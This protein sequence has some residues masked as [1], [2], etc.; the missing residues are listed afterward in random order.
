MKND[1]IDRLEIQKTR[2]KNY[3]IEIETPKNKDIISS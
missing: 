2:F 1:I 3:D